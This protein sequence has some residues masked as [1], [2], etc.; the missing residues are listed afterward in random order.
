M[1][2]RTKTR[3]N[4]SGKTYIY[5]YLVSNKYRK[6]GPK[7]KVKKYLGRVHVLE[8]LKNEQFSTHFTNI[9]TNK[10]PLENAIL[11][12]LK[13][14]LVNHG[15]KQ[16]EN[17]TYKREDIT[18]DLDKC[19]V[20]DSTGNSIYL[21]LNDGYMGNKTLLEVLEYKPPL[22]LDK[23]IGKDL[24][25]KLISSGIMLDS[26]TFLSTFSILKQSLKK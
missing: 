12:L 6:K 24:A 19:K 23:E 2:I 26:N 9:N 13:L 5:A 18:V 3:K 22:G 16:Q 21:A 4:K 14:E 15:F 20:F 1:F 11:E 17:L 7:Q 8:K 10:K 25:K